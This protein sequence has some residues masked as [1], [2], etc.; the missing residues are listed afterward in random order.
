M[1]QGEPRRQHAQRQ[2][3]AEH[4]ARRRERPLPGD[5][6][7]EAV[8][9]AAVIGEPCGGGERM[10]RALDENHLEDAQTGDQ[11]PTQRRDAV[12]RQRADPGAPL[13]P[14]PVRRSGGD[15]RQPADLM[16]DGCEGEDC[17]DQDPLGF[18]V[19]R[20]A[21][22]GSGGQAA[23]PG[24]LR[25]RPG[26]EPGG[27]DED[28][29]PERLGHD[30]SGVGARGQQQGERGGGQRPAPG[31]KLACQSVSQQ[32]A[33]GAERGVDRANRQQ[34]GGHRQPGER[35]DEDEVG[36]AGIPRLHAVPQQAAAGGEVAR[37]FDILQFIGEDDGGRDAEREKPA[38]RPGE[39]QQPGQRQGGLA[40]RR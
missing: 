32:A 6:R 36:P 10:G 13:A 20:Q 14:I 11:R 2:Q 34:C 7:I 19:K 18:D 24:R 26:A 38:D 21:G 30:R 33:E 12:G 39:R 31:Q 15:R 5:Q 1:A 8:G 3:P 9:D 29:D 40:R 17:G 16:N 25:D 35:R 27:A 22:D 4:I 37:H 28:G 23:P